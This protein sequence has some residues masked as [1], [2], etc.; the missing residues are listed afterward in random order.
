MGREALSPKN[1]EHARG[2]APCHEPDES[3]EERIEHERCGNGERGSQKKA[4]SRFR[5]VFVES[6]AFPDRRMC[7]EC[8]EQCRQGP[9]GQIEPIRSIDG[10]MNRR[11]GEAGDD[12]CSTEPES[13]H[14]DRKIGALS[15]CGSKARRGAFFG[16]HM[17][18]SHKDSSGPSC[19]RAWIPISPNRRSAQDSMHPPYPRSAKGRIRLP[20]VYI[21]R[22]AYDLVFLQFCKIRVSDRR[23]FD[24]RCAS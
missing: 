18:P 11:D 23:A 17:Y 24:A 8:H 19:L 13:E 4:E 9:H 15:R 3:E 1:L 21:V 14:D 22:I 16:I 10:S 12:P 6:F 7:R 20:I 5:D 2:N